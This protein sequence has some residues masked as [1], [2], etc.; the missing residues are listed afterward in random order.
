MYEGDCCL[1]LS[2]SAT[3]GAVT[4]YATLPSLPVFG[5]IADCSSLFSIFASSSGLTCWTFTGVCAGAGPVA[6]ALLCGA[7]RFG[8][9]EL[10]TPP[11]S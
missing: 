9:G 8:F 2:R 5:T 6:G 10:E 1:R 4:G 7:T 3:A 11:I